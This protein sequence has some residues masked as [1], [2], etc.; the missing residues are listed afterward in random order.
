MQAFVGVLMSSRFGELTGTQSYVKDEEDTKSELNA[1][2][3]L[4][5]S[6]LIELPEKSHDVLY[7]RPVGEVFVLRQTGKAFLARQ[8]IGDML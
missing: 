4:V 7:N 2:L 8:A 5:V 3:R 1:D 6:V